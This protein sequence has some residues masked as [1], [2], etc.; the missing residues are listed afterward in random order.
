[1]SCRQLVKL[2][3]S[4]FLE[5]KCGSQVRLVD[6]TDILCTSTSWFHLH[7]TCHVA[8]FTNGSRSPSIPRT[9]DW[10]ICVSL[11]DMAFTLTSA[12]EFDKVILDDSLVSVFFCVTFNS[13]PF[14]R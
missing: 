9:I 6:S 3:S 7:S 8:L 4:P 12:E 5:R 1:M 11:T 10:S 14:S 2:H 13:Y